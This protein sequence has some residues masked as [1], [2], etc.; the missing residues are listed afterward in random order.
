MRITKNIIYILLISLITLGQVYA[1]D[2]DLYE[3]RLNS[4]IDKGVISKSEAKTQLVQF[5]SSK[6]ETFHKQVRGVASKFQEA[7]VYQIINE[8]LEIPSH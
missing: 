1:E 8:P 6:Q 4:L 5:N 7:K 2:S 3:Q